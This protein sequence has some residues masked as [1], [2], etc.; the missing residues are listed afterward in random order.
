MTDVKSDGDGLNHGK[1]AQLAGLRSQLR[2]TL[3]K[4][5]TSGNIPASV[6]MDQIRITG[7]TPTMAGSMPGGTTKPVTATTATTTTGAAIATSGATATPQ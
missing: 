3:E 1:F 2:Q 6:E 7:I 5:A 4:T